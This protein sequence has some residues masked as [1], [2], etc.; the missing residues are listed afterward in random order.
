M[1]NYEMHSFVLKVNIAKIVVLTKLFLLVLPEFD[2]WGVDGDHENEN[3]CN[4]FNPAKDFVKEDNVGH[5]CIDDIEVRN[6]TDEAR[7][8]RLEWNCHTV[9]SDCVHNSPT[10]H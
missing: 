5:K 4:Q 9:D 2:N 3:S 7:T 6:Q 8:I 10:N 1:M